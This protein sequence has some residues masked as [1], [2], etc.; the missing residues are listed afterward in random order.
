MVATNNNQQLTIREHA[1]VYSS[2]GEKLGEVI[3]LDR[4][5]VVVQK[6]FVFKSDF[7]IPIGAVARVDDDGVYLLVTKEDALDRGWDINPHDPS[8]GAGG[9]GIPM[10]GGVS[11]LG[12]DGRAT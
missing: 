12:S 5:I 6:G 7:Y 10:T 2:D 3:T 11:W 9:T 1:N 4:D 8:S